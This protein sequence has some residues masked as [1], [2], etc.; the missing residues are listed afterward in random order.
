ME[1]T[2]E[3]RPF[4]L[5]KILFCIL[6]GL[7]ILPVLLA[8][9]SPVLV[10][11]ALLLMIASGYY[12]IAKV[13][14]TIP[15]S[16]C[17]PIWEAVFLTVLNI[18]FIPLDSWEKISQRLLTPEGLIRVAVTT[19]LFLLLYLLEEKEGMSSLKRWQR[20]WTSLLLVFAGIAW[21]YFTPG[22][23]ESVSNPLFRGEQI[24]Y[25]G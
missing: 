15:A 25:G 23:G 11:L 3:I 12:V 6:T 18:S 19:A 14:E 24:V 5:N 22:I 16:G 8:R 13:P 20:R 7:L 1:K 4:L 17:L 21:N 9:F 10:F 2:L